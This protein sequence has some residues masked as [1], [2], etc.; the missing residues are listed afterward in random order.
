MAEKRRSEAGYKKPT[1]A[2]V[3]LSRFGRFEAD[4]RR[5]RV[6][7]LGVV[8]DGGLTIE[9]SHVSSVLGR[10]EFG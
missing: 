3:V 5:F 7:V 2:L 9:R 8:A 10:F 1:I 6:I 4:L